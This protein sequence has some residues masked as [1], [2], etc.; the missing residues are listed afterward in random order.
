MFDFLLEL[1]AELRERNKVLTKSSRE[2][3]MLKDKIK[4]GDAE[5]SRLSEEMHRLRI[6][7]D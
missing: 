4:T 2:I 7:Y 6:E 5:M 1:C 3:D